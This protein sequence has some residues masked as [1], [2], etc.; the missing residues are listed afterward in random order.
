MGEWVAQEGG[1]LGKQKGRRTTVTAL[2]QLMVGKQG[3]GD[4]ANP[5]KVPRAGWE[6]GQAPG[7]RA[8]PAGWGRQAE[9]W[10]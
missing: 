6:P 1:I 3:E 2:A 10:N 8:E 7:S 4:G 5:R 9:L